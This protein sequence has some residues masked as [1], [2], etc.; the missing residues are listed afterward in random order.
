MLKA[1]D[2]SYNPKLPRRDV[3]ELATLK[4]IDSREDILLLG[5]SGT[6]KSHVAKAFAL[7]AVERGYKVAYREAH[8]LFEEI[9]EARQLNKLKKYRAPLIAAQ[10]LVVDDLFLQRLPQGAG[11]E[12]AEILMSRYEKASTII[13]SNRPIEN[14]GE[15]MGDVVI[16][17]PLLD[18]LM[19]HGHLLK[20]DGKSWRLKEAAERSAGRKELADVE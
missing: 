2:W 8:V 13:T 11:D 7:Q 6:G 12:L 15:L 19:H 4:F 5:K 20:F 3:L 18:R 10:L 1:M 16:V 17:A 9:H 14:W